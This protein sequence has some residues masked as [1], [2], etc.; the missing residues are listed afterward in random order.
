MVQEKPTPSIRF[1][2]IGIFL[3]GVVAYFSFLTAYFM[4]SLYAGFSGNATLLTWNRLLYISLP[5]LFAVSLTYFSRRQIK[6]LLTLHLILVA[7]ITL[8]TASIRMAQFNEQKQILQTY[9][10]FIEM[11]KRGKTAEANTFMLPDYQLTHETL[12]VRQHVWLEWAMNTGSVSS[13]YSVYIE[14]RNE[15]IIVPD[16]KT[17]QWYHPSSGFFLEV[18]KFDGKWYFT[19]D[20]GLY[21]VD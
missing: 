1:I 13:P 14:S 20:G 21:S 18:E 5:I 16:P 15:A 19:G 17:N 3:V 6:H 10:Q 11:V 4:A 9:Q 12:D 2:L 8:V 7:L